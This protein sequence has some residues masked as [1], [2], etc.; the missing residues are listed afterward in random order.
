MLTGPSWVAVIVV[1]LILLLMALKGPRMV[2]VLPLE[3]P[4]MDAVPPVTVTTTSTW[5]DSSAAAPPPP[6][7]LIGTL[8]A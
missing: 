3:P 6:T 7:K 5:T 4:G 2:A 8:T 1:W